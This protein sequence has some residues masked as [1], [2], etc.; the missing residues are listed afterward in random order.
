MDKRKGATELFH[1]NRKGRNHPS[2]LGPVQNLEDHVN[3]DWWCRIFNSFYLKTD[4]D[5]VDDLRITRQE[6]D[7]IGQTLELANSDKILDLCCGQGR[8]A[9]ELARR[10]FRNLEGLDRSHYLIQKAKERA[11]IE[12][13][14][15]RFREGDARKLPYAPDSFDLVLILGNSFGYF[16]TL[17]DDLK[18]LREV[19][20]VLRPWGR[21]LIDI[22]DGDYLKES[23]R[24]RSWEWIDNNLFVCRER[25]LSLDRERLVSREVITHVT[26]GVLADQF[27]AERL[28]SQDSLSRLL[29]EAGFGEIA[30]PTSLTTDSER[31]QDLGMMERRIIVSAQARKK[32]TPSRQ[33]H[34]KSQKHVVVLLGDPQKPDP[35]KPLSVFDDDDFYTIDAMKAALRELKGYRFTYLSDHETLIRDLLRLSG[36]ID[37]VFNLCDEGHFNDP[38]KELHVPAIL[39]SMGIPYT[40]SGPQ[41]LAFCYDKSLLRGLAREMGVP[42]PEAFLITPQD[43]KFDVPLDFPVIV[44][45]NF[46]D[47]SFGITARSVAYKPEDLINAVLEI[48]RDFGYEKPI[49]VE[50]FLTGKDLT[51]G[52]IGNPPT[53]YTV[54][55]MA[56]EDYSS[57]PPSLPHICGYEAKWRPESPYGSLKSVPADLP[58]KTKSAIVQWSVALSERL[59]CRDYVRFDWRLD[60]EGNPKILEV[61]PNPGWC[62]DGHLAKMAAN[63]GM[64]YPEMLATILRA[65]E[66]RVGMEPMSTNGASRRDAAP[67]PLFKVVAGAGS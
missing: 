42:V 12:G 4:A 8:H 36:K 47:S 48:R 14:T 22:A 40:G 21:L 25:S 52:M 58:E 65:A 33:R 57:L 7:L 39:E 54:L 9:L 67:A 17:Q 45:P 24:N 35:M 60:A 16:E 27:Y 13:L 5:V 11:K 30:S 29:K 43:S 64:S 37:L 1:K 10:G 51:I 59:E 34:K 23:F 15:V 2:S 55:P 62:W 44:K 56:E 18:V 26:K 50:E 49:L 32:W 63:A 28:Y 46:G 3:P 31:H 38:R 41:C 19:M 6:I 61:N 20:R 53:S 66:E